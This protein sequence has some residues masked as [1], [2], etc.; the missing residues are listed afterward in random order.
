M[1]KFNP[2]TCPGDDLQTALDNANF[3]LSELMDERRVIDAKIEDQGRIKTI[4]LRRGKEL[5]IKLY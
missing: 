2:E 4:V 1:K 3:N 5:N